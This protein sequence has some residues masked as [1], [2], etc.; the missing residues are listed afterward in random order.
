MPRAKTPAPARRS[1]YAGAGSE[2]I[3]AM[4]ARVAPDILG[5]LADGAPRPRPS[6]ITG[7]AELNARGIPAPRG[8]EWS[9]I[10]V[11]RLLGRGAQQA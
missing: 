7:T 4:V 9:S 1:P 2:A 10:A 11:M 5:L 3:N 8:G 6:A